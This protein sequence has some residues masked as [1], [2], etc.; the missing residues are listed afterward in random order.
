MH[1]EAPTLGTDQE[2]PLDTSPDAQRSTNHWCGP[3]APTG[4][5]SWGTERHP[6]TL[7]PCFSV[8]NKGTSIETGNV[9]PTL[10]IGIRIDRVL[11]II[12]RKPWESRCESWGFYIMLF[13]SICPNFYSRNVITMDCRSHTV[14]ITCTHPNKQKEVIIL[15]AYHRPTLSKFLPNHT[16][17]PTNFL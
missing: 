15:W 13:R 9:V 6:S 11:E 12:K 4:H 5:L 8:D 7:P 16:L 1:R 14:D 10:Y 3:G 2:Q 17:L